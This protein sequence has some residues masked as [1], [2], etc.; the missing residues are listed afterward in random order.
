MLDLVPRVADM[1]RSRRAELL[2][3]ADAVTS[4]LRRTAPT[5]GDA[6]L[7]AQALADAAGQLTDMFDA[8]HGGFGGAPKFPTPHNLLF[9]LRHWHRS[10]DTH[11]LAMVERTLSAMRNG[12]IYDHVGFGFHRYSTDAEWLVPHF[13]KMLYD[14]ALLA[15]AYT[16]AHLATGRDDYARTAREVLSYVL[17]DM[18]APEGGFYSAEDADSEGVEGKFYTW[19]LDEISTVLDRREAEIAA[20]AF[21][22]REEGNF[23]EEATGRRTG[24]N[25]LHRREAAE[26]ARA[27]GLTEDELAL[28]LEPIRAKL[29][30]ARKGRIHPHKDDKILTDWNGLMIAALAT[31]GRALDEPEHLAAAARAADFILSSMRDSDGRLLH[32]YRDGQ[33]A[34]RATADD[35]AFLMWGLLDLY[36]AAFEP[37]HLEAAIALSDEFVSHFWDD[38]GGFYFSADDAES[39]LTRRKDVYDGATPSSNSVAML[40]LVRLGRLTGNPEYEA[41][42]S[43]LSRSVGATVIRHPAAYTHLMAALDLALG[44][45]REIVIVGAPDARDTAELIAS[46]RA[47][48]LPRSVVLVRPPGD[49]SRLSRSAP[50]TAPLKSIDGRA[51]AYVCRDFRCDLPTTDRATLLDMLSHDR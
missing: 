7:G 23:S 39:L 27:L 37:R 42:A 6:E 33:A 49:S 45:S 31:A 15:I 44:P 3:T 19:T 35:Y 11:S 32:R 34:I 17:R 5:E 9:L 50:W 4:A 12:G 36:E 18:T 30:A 1:W 8:E 24:A 47:S 48:Y 2:E 51:T 22:V 46:L 20:R 26:V 38:R 25:I 41:R 10:G 40:N 28:A 13:E 29:F 43:A 16:E 21:G 14:Q